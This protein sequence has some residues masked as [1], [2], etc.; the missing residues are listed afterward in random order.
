LYQKE[1]H[2]FLKEAKTMDKQ[3]EKSHRVVVVLTAEEKEKLQEL[4]RND[5]RSMSGFLRILLYNEVNR[6]FFVE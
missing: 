1:Q 3:K 5:Q 4:A 2:I 6:D